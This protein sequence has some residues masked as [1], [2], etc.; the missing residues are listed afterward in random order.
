MAGDGFAI[1]PGG[2]LVLNLP[3]PP[4]TCLTPKKEPYGIE[5][6]PSGFFARAQDS[7][8]TGTGDGSTLRD[9]EMAGDPAVQDLVTFEEVAIYFSEKEWETLTDWQKGLYLDVMKDNY[10]N[11]VSLG[12][13]AQPPQRP[14]ADR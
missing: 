10:K 3:V 12:L 7:N 1:L 14:P 2:P 11:L 4:K 5:E 13:A 9:E 8:C 6:L